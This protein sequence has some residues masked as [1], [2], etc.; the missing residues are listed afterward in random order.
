MAVVSRDAIEE[1]IL[2]R[3]GE[4]RTVTFELMRLAAAFVATQTAYATATNALG[5][6]VARALHRDV[7]SFAHQS[8]FKAAAAARDY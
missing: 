6:Q 1:P 8:A 7:L 5:R 4:P 3:P 2:L